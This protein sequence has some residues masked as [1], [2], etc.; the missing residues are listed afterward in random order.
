MCCVCRRPRS[1]VFLRGNVGPQV[2][3]RTTFAKAARDSAL[4]RY[5]DPHAA[6]TAP[7]RSQALARAARNL[8]AGY[9]RSSVRKLTD[10][11]AHWRLS[12]SSRI[13]K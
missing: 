6:A 1:S 3:H 9:V 4:G 10:T 8:L 5:A 7:T 12:F 2:K 13:C 11:P